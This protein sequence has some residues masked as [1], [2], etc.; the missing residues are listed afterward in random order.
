MSYY[1]DMPS[2]LTLRWSKVEI[3]YPTKQ[4]YKQDS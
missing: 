2:K 4:D 3:T 1:E